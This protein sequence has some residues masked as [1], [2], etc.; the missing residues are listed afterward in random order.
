MKEAVKTHF[1]GIVENYQQHFYLDKSGINFNFRKRLEIS[2][3]LTEN[4]S[5]SLLE[6]AVGTGEVTSAILESDQF[7][8]VRIVDI[9][10]QMLNHAK[11]RI[12]A[13]NRIENIVFINSDIFDY[14]ASSRDKFNL[15]ICLG[16][17]A[18]VGQL[19]IL[20]GKLKNK[21]LPGGA[22]LLQ[23]TLNDHIGTKIVRYLTQDKYSKNHGYKISYFDQKD[24]ETSCVNV[25]LKIIDVRRYLVGLPFGDKIWPLANYYLES[26]FQGWANKNGSEAIYLLSHD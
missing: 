2:C 15:I 21:L 24:I 19:D 22:I 10:P 26:K 14:L 8:S 17:I 3:E 1:E 4:Y 16:L 7:S 12:L 9:S 5:G 6:C 18:H 20:L 13:E 25:G 23:T 11:K